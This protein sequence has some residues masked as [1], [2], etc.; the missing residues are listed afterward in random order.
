MEADPDSAYV[1]LSGLNRNRLSED[2]SAL[3]SLLFT[4]AQIK[5]GIAVT[6][7]SLIQVAYNYYLTK[8]SDEHR[9]RAFF[10]NAKVMF[11]AKDCPRAMKDVLV[12]HEI[13][14]DINNPYWIARSAELIS[15]IFF[16]VYNYPEAAKFTKE[17]IKNYQLAGRESCLRYASCDLAVIYMNDGK[18]ARAKEILDSL[19]EIA[20]SI[21]EEDS[22]YLEY[23][24]G[25][26]VAIKMKTEDSPTISDRELGIAD[27]QE[28]PNT[29][30][31]D[32]LDQSE[33]FRSKGEFD[34]SLMALENVKATNT[35]QHARILYALFLHH[36]DAGNYEEALALTDSL[37]IIQSEI[38]TKIMQESV[39][40]VQRD[41]YSDRA[42]SEKVKSQQMLLL[43]AGVIVV[44]VIIITLLWII[45]RLRMRN[46]SDELEL[47]INSLVELRKRV[48]ISDNDNRKLTD[49]LNEETS[50]IKDLEAK[51][52]ERELS[53]NFNIKLIEML[54]KEK[55]VTLNM[56]CNN[57]F[58]LGDSEKTRLAILKNIE[59][60][61]NKQ[62]TQKNLEEIESAVD[63][64][65][66]G[67][68]SRM[69]SECTFLKDADFTFLSLIFAGLSVRAICLFTGIKYKNFYLRK[70]RL[71]KRIEASDAPGKEIYLDRLR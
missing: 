14:R 61:I 63:L 45:Y 64:Y 71:I 16:E 43:L 32:L 10:Y 57:Y 37:L 31:D 54:F 12:A 68:M 33:Y 60:E 51:L 41:F 39:T 18:V 36:R 66:G 27:S 29:F 11:N 56:L 40:G 65:L 2:N 30:I 62:R 49:R 24:R 55:W 15:D 22:F 34:K 69:R 20:L 9:L 38:A 28:E 58:D 6:S 52:V 26:M 47:A 8:E 13:A 42:A 17:A 48:D 25:P 23:I 44:A 70:S 1:L 5:I 21:Q 46:R 7:D 50:T 35:G 53:G 4:Q 19:Y 67:I 3:Y 59:I